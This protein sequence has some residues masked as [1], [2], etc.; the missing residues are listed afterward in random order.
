MAWF[1]NLP[2]MHLLR[3][4]QMNLVQLIIPVESAHDTVA[5]LAE[6]GLLQIKD[7]NYEK[8]PFQRTYANQVLS[9]LEMTKL[10]LHGLSDV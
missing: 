1:R 8:S 9:C 5:Y 7:L 3:S 6:L 4:E 2:A 10:L